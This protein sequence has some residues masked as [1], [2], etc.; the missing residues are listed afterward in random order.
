MNSIYQDI[1]NQHPIGPD[2]IILSRDDL[3]LKAIAP[4]YMFF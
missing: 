2:K 4:D 1:R 3:K